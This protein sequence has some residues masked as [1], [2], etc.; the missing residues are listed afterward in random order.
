MKKVVYILGLVGVILMAIVVLTAGESGSDAEQ[1]NISIGSEARLV[2]E[3][4]TPYV[5]TTQDTLD[6]LLDAVAANDKAGFNQIL[7][8]DAVFAVPQDT[9]VLLVDRDFGTYEVRILEGTHEG[10]S[11]WVIEEMV[12]PD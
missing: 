8:S 5:C 10:E 12:V 4:A 9:L 7:M 2:S 3:S 6:A 11:G 1:P